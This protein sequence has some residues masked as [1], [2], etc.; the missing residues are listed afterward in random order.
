MSM[1]TSI[2]NSGG[3]GKPSSDTMVDE[4][5]GGGSYRPLPLSDFGTYKSLISVLYRTSTAV[6]LGNSLEWLDFS[7]YGYSESDISQQLFGG[8]TTV[9]WATFGLGFAFRPVGAYVLGKLSDEKSRNLSF[10]IAMLSMATSTAL[11]SLI[12]AVC[13]EPGVTVKYCVP[14][15]LAAAIPAVFLRCIQ[16]FSAG[17]A[18]KG[19][20]KGYTCLKENK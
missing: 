4:D 16:G 12:P 19:N 5:A 15:L 1:N 18:C 13:D 3:D 8:S 10:I 6:I 11:M 14:N 17:A 9:G 20:I 7:I 2:S